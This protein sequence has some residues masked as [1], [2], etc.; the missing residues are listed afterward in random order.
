[1]PGVYFN[2]TN[3]QGMMVSWAQIK[4]EAQSFINERGQAICRVCAQDT[5]DEVTVMGG[6]EMG[7]RCDLCGQTLQQ[8]DWG[9]TDARG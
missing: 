7:Q 4:T 8:N 5:A 9:G 1:M 3:G 6:V 2:R